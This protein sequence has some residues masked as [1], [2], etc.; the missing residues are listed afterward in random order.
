MNQ[1]KTCSKCRQ[2]KPFDAFSAHNGSKASKSGLRSTCKSCDVEYN[3]LYRAANREK[4][5]AAKREWAKNN[6]HLIRPGDSA[7][8]EKNKE[9]LSEYHKQWKKLNAEHVQDYQ[10]KYLEANR[11]RKKASD[12]AWAEKNKN[13]I[14]HA[15]RRYRARNPEKVKAIKQAQAKKHPETVKNNKLR[16]RARIADNGV[17]LVTKKDIAKIMKNPCAYCGA[18]SKH[19][20]HVIPIAKGGAHKVGNLVAACQS[21][22]Q[23][24]SDKFVSVWKAGK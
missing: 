1:Y 17:Y 11:E 14:N 10:R 12:K 13:K 3:R 16:R 23:R 5:N 9:R 7:Y 6:R 24:K 8:R 20:D 15:S 18:T 4:V 2:Q 21:C 22:N 19:I